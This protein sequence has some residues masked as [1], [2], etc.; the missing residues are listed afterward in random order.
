[1]GTKNN[2][3]RYDAIAA[4]EPDEPYFV[5]IGRD[6]GA[7]K[8]VREWAANASNNGTDG[9]KVMEALACAADME[10]FAMEFHARPRPPVVP[11][12]NE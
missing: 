2:P 5:L 7:A 8:L 6:R 1:M 3:S 4:A 11:I 12:E 10:K 9:D